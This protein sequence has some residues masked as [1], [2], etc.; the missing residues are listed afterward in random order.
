MGKV[1]V[2]DKY[3]EFLDGNGNVILKVQG[4]ESAVRSAYLNISQA[5]GMRPVDG[6]GRIIYQ[7]ESGPIEVRKMA[8]SHLR[9]AILKEWRDNVLPKL[10]AYSWRGEAALEELLCVPGCNRSTFIYSETLAVLV[11]EYRTR[12]GI[13]LP[14]APVD[15]P[16]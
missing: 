2:E 12:N 11:E 6:T 10:S 9:N 8:D 5:R 13:M 7:S 1:K 3:Y 14:Y 15:I 16:F 4:E